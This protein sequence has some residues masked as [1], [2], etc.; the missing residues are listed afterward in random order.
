MFVILAKKSVYDY[1]EALPYILDNKKV[2]EIINDDIVYI[3][4]SPNA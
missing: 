2:I 3:K 4:L 1:D